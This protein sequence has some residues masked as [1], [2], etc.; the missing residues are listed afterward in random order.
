[1]KKLVVVLGLLLVLALVATPAN[2]L[3]GGEVDTVHT[4]VGAIVMYWPQFG[5]DGRLCTATLIHPQ[6]L[7]TAAKP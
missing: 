2:A 3:V 7:V 4:N 6:A 1:M 5:Y